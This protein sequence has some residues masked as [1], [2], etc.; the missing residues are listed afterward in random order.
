MAPQPDQDA[1]KLVYWDEIEKCYKLLSYK[2][3]QADTIEDG[4]ISLQ[5]FKNIVRST[6][7]LTPKEKNLLIRLQKN[8][9][10]KYSEFPDMLYNVRYEIAMSETME[11]NMGD[12]SYYLRREFARED[13]DDT[14]VISVQQC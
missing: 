3:K 7:F 4:M 13:K 12:M 8:D 10:I 11:S 14:K 5:H 9:M 6:K 2:F 1:L